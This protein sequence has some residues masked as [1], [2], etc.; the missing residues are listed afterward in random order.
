MK[1]LLFLLAGL[2]LANIPTIKSQVYT[3]GSVTFTVTTVSNGGAFSPKHVLAIW[4]KNSSGTFV[5]T[6]K[7]Q[8][9]Q[10]IQYLNQWKVSS[11]LNVVNA[12]TGA[13]LSNHQTHTLTWNCTNLSGAVVADGNYDF[14]VE[15]ADDDAVAGPYTHYTFNKSTTSVS[16]NFPNQSRFINATINYTPQPSAISENLV[17]AKANVSYNDASNSFTMSIPASGNHNSVLKVFD[18]SGRQVFQTDQYTEDSEG[19]H[20]I[21]NSSDKKE[22]IYIYKIETQDNSVY[23]GKLLNIR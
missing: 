21:W 23:S 15:F 6:L 1:I 18:I 11:G 19:R 22:N 20:F 10:R 7:R 14:W 13:T 16:T 2:F 3:P 4:I 8:A 5:R 17:R 12:I 9:V